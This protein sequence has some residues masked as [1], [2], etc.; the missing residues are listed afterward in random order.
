MTRIPSPPGLDQ[1][2]R[3][4][5]PIRRQPEP[6]ADLESFEQHVMAADAPEYVLV[7]RNWI[8][9]LLRY[10]RRLDRDAGAMWE[11]VGFW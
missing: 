6:P 4:E 3:L 7:D 10:V 9:E 2:E 5:H 11:D 8:R 1:L